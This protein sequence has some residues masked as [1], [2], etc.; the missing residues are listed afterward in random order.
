M[1]IEVRN[2][3]FA[4]HGRVV[5]NEISLSLRSGEFLGLLG[6]NGSGK[7]TFLKNLLG[8][9]KPKKGSIV[10][11]G[12]PDP[13]GTGDPARFLAFVPQRPA[14]AMSLPVRELVLMGRLP[15]IRSRWAGYGEQDYQKVE[16]ALSA[17]GI[18]DLADRDA[19]RLSGGEL[20]KVIICRCLV[21][22]GDVFLLDEVTS[23]LDLNHTI[24]IMEL[25]RRK[26]DEEG[27]LIVAV[28]HD[29]NLASRYCDRLVFIK[30]GTIRCQGSPF[31]V[32]T[33]RVVE[34][35]Y[36]IRALVEKGE[37]GKP[38]V[39]PRRAFDTPGR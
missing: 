28:F 5:L 31:E 17:L 34:D 3:S 38:V 21:Q 20:Q 25:I 12:V 6:P 32:L 33:E 36:G 7:T 2:L 1:D 13:P 19:A 22:E 27:K 30:N 16:A 15:H 8:Y 11:S 26:A 39:L 4:Y 9:L 23:G 18:T 14:L 35:I 37:D 10:F 29:L 24:E